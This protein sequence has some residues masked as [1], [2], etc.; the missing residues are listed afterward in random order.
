M[1]HHDPFVN[2]R[3]LRWAAGG[4]G[5]GSQPGL[6]LLELCQRRN[7]YAAVLHGQSFGAQTARLLLE[8][9]RCFRKH[10]AAASAKDAM[11]GE[12]QLLRGHS[13]RKSGLTSAAWQARGSGDSAIG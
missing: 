2:E 13:Q 11:P 8:L 9:P 3:T 5:T 10:N 12:V 6:E 7:R 4:T 1:Y